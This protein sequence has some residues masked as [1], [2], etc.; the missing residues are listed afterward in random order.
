MKMPDEISSQDWASWSHYVLK[1][2][3]RLNICFGIIATDVAESRRASEAVASALKLDNANVANALK[4]DNAKIA[5]GLRL[6]HIT[7]ISKLKEDHGKEI[8]KIWTQ[9]SLLQLKSGLWGA[10]AGVV[11]TVAMLLMGLFLGNIKLHL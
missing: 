9:I 6:E 10:T 11:T 7:T 1:E 5:E 2:L 3:E 8:G 4:T